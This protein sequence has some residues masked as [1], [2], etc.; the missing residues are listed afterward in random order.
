MDNQEH[1]LEGMSQLITAVNRLVEALSGVQD[2]R[3][4]DRHVA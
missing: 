1:L 2:G 4:S 3:G